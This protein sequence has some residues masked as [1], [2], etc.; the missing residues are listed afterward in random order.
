MIDEGYQGNGFLGGLNLL[1]IKYSAGL[2]SLNNIFQ[3][4]F[5]IRISR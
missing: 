5:M 2:V 4:L 3:V 1:G